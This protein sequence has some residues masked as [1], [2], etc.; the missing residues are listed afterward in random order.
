MVGKIVNSGKREFTR[1]E[2]KGDFDFGNETKVRLGEK[3]GVKRA[4]QQAKGRAAAR[5]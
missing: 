1:G 4:E 2:E 5:T 3:I